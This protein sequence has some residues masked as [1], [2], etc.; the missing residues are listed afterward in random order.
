MSDVLYG[1]TRGAE[2]VSE[3]LYRHPTDQTWSIRHLAARHYSHPNRDPCENRP[4]LPPGQKLV[5][6]T[7]WGDAGI[8]MVFQKQRLDEQKGVYMSFFRNESDVLS[9][10]LLVEAVV[11]AWRLRWPGE[12]F[13]TFVDE[14]QVRS[15][16]PGYC[17][18]MA[19][20]DYAG[21]TKSRNLLI[22]RHGGRFGPRS[23]SDGCD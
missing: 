3:H 9:S 22:F 2:K 8:G 23:L 7:E 4:I 11:A 14:T 5:L 12:P 10:R 16:N 6:M 21:R 17:F 15:H 19:G 18:K 1:K 13:F 20:W